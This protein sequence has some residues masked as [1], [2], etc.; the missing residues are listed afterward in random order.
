MGNNKNKKRLTKVA[1]Q[2][3]VKLTDAQI[4]R[5]EIRAKMEVAKK[6]RKKSVK[7]VRINEH[8]EEVYPSEESEENESKSGDDEKLKTEITSDE[9]LE[10]DAQEIDKLDESRSWGEDDE[11]YLMEQADQDIINSTVNWYEIETRMRKLMY[12]LLKPL[13]DRTFKDRERI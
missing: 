2:A 13:V 11:E 5:A 3:E 6:E 4:I 7:L 12:S 1:T 10:M 9:Q 8:D